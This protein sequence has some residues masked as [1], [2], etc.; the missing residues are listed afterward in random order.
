MPKVSQLGSANTEQ[1]EQ[2]MGPHKNEIEEAAAY[3]ADLSADLAAIARNHTLSMLG[4]ILDLA[5]AEARR[6]LT[7][8]RREAR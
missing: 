5:Q 7:L 4:D 3:V 2:S 6:S 1:R 8:M